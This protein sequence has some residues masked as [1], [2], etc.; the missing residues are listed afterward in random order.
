MQSAPGTQTHPTPF[1]SPGARGFS[2]QT[3]RLLQAP[4]PVPPSPPNG[5]SGPLSRDAESLPLRE[6]PQVSCSSTPSHTRLRRTGHV[7]LGLV[8]GSRRG[9]VDLHLL[10]QAA[11]ESQ[12]EGFGATWWTFEVEL[13]TSASF[14]SASFS[15][16]RGRPPPGPVRFSS[17]TAGSSGW[18]HL[19]P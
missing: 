14:K 10:P 19:R 2:T 7:T 3:A 8:E 4:L 5:S 12:V 17:P 18:S 16:T 11:A 6:C 15:D 9:Q 1:S 13:C